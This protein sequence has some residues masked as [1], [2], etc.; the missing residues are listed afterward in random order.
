MGL[1]RS[2][3]MIGFQ[4]SDSLTLLLLDEQHLWETTIASVVLQSG[5]NR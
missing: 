2:V 1:G 4:L 3:C 5:T